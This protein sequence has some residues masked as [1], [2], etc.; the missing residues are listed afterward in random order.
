[1]H[2]TVLLVGGEE[3]ASGPAGLVVTHRVGDII[4]VSVVPPLGIVRAVGSW[5]AVLVVW[6]S[7]WTATAVTVTGAAACSTHSGRGGEQRVPGQE[8]GYA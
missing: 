6:E 1:M 4:G 8:L 3:L 7:L 5:S 2:R